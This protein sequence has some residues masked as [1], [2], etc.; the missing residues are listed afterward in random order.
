MTVFE[1]YSLFGAPFVLLLVV[2]SVVWITGWQ[3]KREASR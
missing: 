2:A 1:L 3:D